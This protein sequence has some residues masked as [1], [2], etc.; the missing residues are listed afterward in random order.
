MNII[1]TEIPD[2][3]KKNINKTKLKLANNVIQNV[4]PLFDE[5]YEGKLKELKKSEDDLRTKKDQVLE[6]KDSLQIKLENYN[7]TKKSEHLIN[8]ISKLISSGLVFEGN[9]KREI[10]ILLKVIDKLTNEKID[11]HMNETLK[12]INKRF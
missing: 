11:Y 8:R 4:F 2:V 3:T 10:I 9:L 12:L 6:I 5:V 1:N 7:K